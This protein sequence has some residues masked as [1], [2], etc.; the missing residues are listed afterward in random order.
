VEDLPP[1][2]VGVVLDEREPRQLR[3]I[4]KDS[5]SIGWCQ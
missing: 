1:H 5:Q 3:A 2:P 4:K